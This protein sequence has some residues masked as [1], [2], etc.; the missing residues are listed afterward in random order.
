MFF[1][2]WFIN[3]IILIYSILIEEK[4]EVKGNAFSS[5]YNNVNRRTDTKDLIKLM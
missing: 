1:V 3:N 4:T 5:S 2:C